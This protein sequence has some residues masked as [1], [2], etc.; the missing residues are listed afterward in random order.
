[1]DTPTEESP[2]KATINRSVANPEDE[3]KNQELLSTKSKIDSSE[4]LAQPSMI[5]VLPEAEAEEQ[6]KTTPNQFSLTVQS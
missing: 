2:N 4:L 1:M 3:L 5:A 6:A